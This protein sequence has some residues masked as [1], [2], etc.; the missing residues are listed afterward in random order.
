MSMGAQAKLVHRIAYGDRLTYGRVWERVWELVR[1]AKAAI[2]RYAG[3]CL[4][5]N[6]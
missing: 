1:K 2:R 4:T 3:A 5:F 6:L